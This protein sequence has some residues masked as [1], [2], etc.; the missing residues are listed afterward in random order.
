[1]T[2]SLELQLD[3][4]RD[5]IARVGPEPLFAAP[6]VTPEDAWFPDRWSPDL[7]C[8]RRILL[9][10]AE[11]VGLQ[12]LDVEVAGFPEETADTQMPVSLLERR[13]ES[14]A[15]GLFYGIHDGCAWFGV[16]E[17]QLRT[18]QR[19]IGVLAHELA[20]AWRHVHDVHVE[21]ER[22]E[23]E[24]TDLTTVVLGFGILL[25]N[26]AYEFQIESTVVGGGYAT[27]KWAHSTMG[28]LSLP[29]LAEVL[30]CWAMLKDLP[31]ATIRRYLHGAQAHEFDAA[32]E[33]M[34][35]IDLLERLGIP[36]IPERIA[37]TPEAARQR[38]FTPSRAARN[39]HAC[40]ARLVELAGDEGGL[41]AEPPSF[42]ERVLALPHRML[43]TW[44]RIS[45]AGTWA[46]TL[47]LV[48]D[49]EWDTQAVVLVARTGS[50]FGRHAMGHIRDRQA[51]DVRGLLAFLVQLFASGSGLRALL[52]PSLPTFATELPGAGA[53]GVRELERV[54]RPLA[55]DAD[56]GQVASETAWLRQH[57]SHTMMRLDLERAQGGIPGVPAA[58]RADTKL[59][60]EA[61]SDGQHVTDELTGLDLYVAAL[62]SKAAV[63]WTD[64]GTE[65]GGS[66]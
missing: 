26:A 1:M 60:W 57:R 46:R 24:C 21:P 47:A 13:S 15:A 56:P 5:L 64:P 2:P 25:C 34:S 35:E 51:A 32:W 7:E 14:G 3:R 39:V 10:M 55:D 30:A 63:Q 23:E 54:F 29:D 28:Y 4:M 38:E 45:A 66:G 58:G 8:V 61:V 52:C 17:Q 48:S 27:T 22:L 19:L 65:D 42:P 41:V 33:R 50:D 9:R 44:G 31:P 36:E 20:H 53:L 11:V 62:E 16:E 18:P 6:L 43:A 37:P 40:V 59:W 12:D 49:P